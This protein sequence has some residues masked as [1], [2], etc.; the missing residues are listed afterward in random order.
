[1]GNL[2]KLIFVRFSQKIFFLK[3]VKKWFLIKKS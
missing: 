3:N 2:E 1:M